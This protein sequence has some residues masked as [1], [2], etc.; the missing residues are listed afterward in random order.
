MKEKQTVYTARS[1]PDNIDIRITSDQI[2]EVQLYTWKD[3]A[4][5]NHQTEIKKRQINLLI[6]K[7]INIYTNI[8]N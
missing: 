5:T 1:Q 6:Y 7:Y 4:S 8:I 2:T 3:T